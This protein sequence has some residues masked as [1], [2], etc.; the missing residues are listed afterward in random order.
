MSADDPSVPHDMEL[1]KSMVRAMA[2]KAVALEDENP[3]LKARSSDTPFKVG[4][5]DQAADTYP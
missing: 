4:L 3:A 5:P 2:Q 1:L